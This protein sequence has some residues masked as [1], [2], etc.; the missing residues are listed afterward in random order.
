MSTPTHF[1]TVLAEFTSVIHRSK[2]RQVSI[3]SDAQRELGL[4][5][6]RENHLLLVSIRIAGGGRWNHHYFK[7]TADNEFAIPSDVANV[8]AGD[9][10]EVKVHRI[11]AD[12]E[13]G[14]RHPG[15]A[16][17]LAE[18]ARRPRKGWRED[19]SSD[20][21]RYLNDEISG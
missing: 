6:R 12:V 16:S 3:P 19:G 18:L 15:A 8:S 2:N 9:R 21:D 14:A 1:G 7:L 5:K 10:I 11:I 17:R 4:K 13:V 20:L